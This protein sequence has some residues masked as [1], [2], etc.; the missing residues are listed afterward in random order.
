MIRRPRYAP[1]DAERIALNACIR[2]EEVPSK[3]APGAMAL[4]LTLVCPRCKMDQR[5]AALAHAETITRCGCGINMI[6]EPDCVWVWRRTSRSFGRVASVLFAFV[7]LGATALAVYSGLMLLERGAVAAIA[8]AIKQGKPKD[9]ARLAT[10][11]R[12]R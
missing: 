5:D 11:E 8:D 10:W 9:Q 2:C 12:R 3:F 4:K 7:I 6:A 1:A